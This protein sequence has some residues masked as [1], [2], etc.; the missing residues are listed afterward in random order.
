MVSTVDVVPLFE[1]IEDLENAPQVLDTLL[2]NPC[3]AERRGARRP[4]GGHGRLLGQQQ[5]RRVCHGQLETVRRPGSNSRKSQRRTAIALR[6]FHGR[7]GAVGRGG[8]PADKAILA[9]PPGSVRGRIKIT[10]QGEVIAARYFDEEDRLSQPG[11]D[12]PRRPAA[13]ADHRR[14]QA[15]PRPASGPRRWT[16]CR[17]TA[18]RAY[19][20][21]VYDDPEFVRFFQETTPIGELA[22]LNIG[23]RPPKRTASDR[24]EDLRAIPWVFSWMQ[25]RYTLPGWYGLGTALDAVRR[26]V[27]RQHLNGLQEMYREWTFFTTMLD[28]AQMSL[29]KA[30][31][32][33]A[34]RYAGLVTDQAM[35]QR[36]Y[37]SHSGRV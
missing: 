37:R 4:A 7:G 31:M 29:A 24:I 32:D 27:T 15:A 2:S 26:P 23:S 6:L 10:E 12:R 21:L 22:Q 8:G 20:A 36:I 30:D 19:R 25:S 33:I 28:N 5:G 3:T 16:R 18:F 34:A 35:G 9:Q 1:T 14:R 13:S 11:T 17:T